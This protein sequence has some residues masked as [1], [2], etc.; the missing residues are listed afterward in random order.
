MN[1]EKNKV[2]FLSSSEEHEKFNLLFFPR[3]IQDENSNEKELEDFLLR[4]RQKDS[5]EVDL[6]KYLMQ[7]NLESSI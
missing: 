3:K 6:Y 7:M 5:I 2:S 1:T 4:K